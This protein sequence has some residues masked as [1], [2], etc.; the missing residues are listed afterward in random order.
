MKSLLSI[1]FDFLQAV[2]RAE[3]LEQSAAAMKKIAEEELEVSL[4]N[5]AVS[6]TGENA[7]EYLNKVFRLKEKMSITS[8]NLNQAARVVREIAQR[9]YE[10]EKEAL[11]IATERDYQM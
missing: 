5:L 8:E 7:R 3:E 4:Q 6:W 9:T 10:A 11:E 1:E 2:K